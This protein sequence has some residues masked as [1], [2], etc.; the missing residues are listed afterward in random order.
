[1]AWCTAAVSP[2]AITCSRPTVTLP[3]GIPRDIT[4][5]A[6]TA[7]DNTE[8]PFHTHPACEAIQFDGC[9]VY[10]GGK[11]GVAT[12]YSH[13]FSI[14]GK[15]CVANNPTVKDVYGCAIIIGNDAYDC[16]INNPDIS[17]CRTIAGA[18]GGSSDAGNGILVGQFTG[19]DVNGAHKILGGRIS[20]CEKSG[21]YI[22]SNSTGAT[23]GSRIVGTYIKPGGTAGS[24][25]GVIVD[26]PGDLNWTDRITVDGGDEAIHYVNPATPTRRHANLT[27]IGTTAVSNKANVLA[28]FRTFYKTA[29]GATTVADGDAPMAPDN[30]D[31]FNHYDTTGG[32]AYLSIRANGAWKVM[33]GPV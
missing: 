30:G 25:Y 26:D 11:K 3:A 15:R 10:G 19:H 8:A 29:A 6:C 22:V 33:A 28:T 16:V 9:I 7:R 18:A 13:G 4:V 5:S 24:K 1:M 31:Q 32:K 20:D 2:A 14:N 12:T 23:N 21:I 17:A 27:T